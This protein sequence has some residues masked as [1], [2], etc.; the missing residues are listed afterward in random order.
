VTC[1]E[2]PGRVYFSPA[3]GSDIEASAW[4]CWQALA[5]Q[6]LL[7]DLST[8]LYVQTSDQT[9]DRDANRGSITSSI[10]GGWKVWRGA[11]G[12]L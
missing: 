9:T 10:Q 4:L 5:E 6:R 8:V 3:D 7:V 11:E 12:R 1:S 2:L